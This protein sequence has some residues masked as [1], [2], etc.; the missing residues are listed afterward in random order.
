MTLTKPQKVTPKIMAA[1]NKFKIA[2]SLPSN[3]ALAKQLNVSAA[4]ISTWYN[5]RNAS[6][7]GPTW[8]KIKE[9]IKPHIDNT[10]RENDAAL[11]ILEKYEGSE[12]QEFIIF[13]LAKTI[14]NLREIVPPHIEDLS[15]R[16]RDLIILAFKNISEAIEV[17]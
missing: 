13:E 9:R 4:T 3:Y 11:G 1:L 14:A 7:S 8:D 15:G 10:V 2:E 17:N 6:I 12:S 16:R 5:K